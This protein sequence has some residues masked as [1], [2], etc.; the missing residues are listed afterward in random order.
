[1]FPP[2]LADAKV[3]PPMLVKITMAK[4]LCITVDIC[5]Q[6]AAMMMFSNDEEK[7]RILVVIEEAKKF[8]EGCLADGSGLAQ[9]CQAVG[10]VLKAPGFGDLLAQGIG[11]YMAVLISP[12]DEELNKCDDLQLSKTLESKIDEAKVAIDVEE[13]TDEA[14]AAIDVEEK[15]D[16]VKVAI[17]VEEKKEEVVEGKKEEV[18]E[19]KKEEVVEEKAVQVDTSTTYVLVPRCSGTTKTGVQCK[20]TAVGKSGCCHAHQRQGKVRGMHQCRG[21]TVYKNQ[22][23]NYLSTDD[24]YCYAHK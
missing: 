1:L 21:T 24:L 18:V 16:E 9:F 22:C 14:K 8:A 10:K 3:I 13:K 19:E 6:L 2:D 11:R 4:R 12:P 15:T 17:D 20:T 5:T 23:R 7:K